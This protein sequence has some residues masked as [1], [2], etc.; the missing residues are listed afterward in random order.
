[1]NDVSNALIRLCGMREM[2]HAVASPADNTLELNGKRLHFDMLPWDVPVT[3]MVYGTLLNYKGALAALGDAVNQPPYNAPPKA[4]VLYIK[5]VNTHIGYGMPIPLSEDIEEIAIGA[6]LGVVIGRTATRVSESAALDY[7]AG[8]TIVNDVSVPHDQVYRPAVKQLARDGF[9]P[10]GPWLIKPEAIQ[11]PDS[12]GIRVYVNRELRQE[13]TTAN[14]IRPIPRLIA[15]ITDF[16]TLYAGDVLLVGIPEH[17]PLAKA[18]D[19]VR[20][21]IDGIG[22]LEN[23]VVPEHQIVMAGGGIA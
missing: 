15:E 2:E 9:C 23:P 14:L 20:V 1:M 3:G 17:A 12:L 8:Y 10:I 16:M 13:N 7:V 22:Y 5:P 4:P 18:G 21:E 19:R 6:A 11:H